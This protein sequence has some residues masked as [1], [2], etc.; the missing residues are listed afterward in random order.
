MAYLL[1]AAVQA[2]FVASGCAT[3]AKENFEES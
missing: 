1:K 2:S 3:S